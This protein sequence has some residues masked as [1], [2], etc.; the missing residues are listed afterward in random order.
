MT[1]L[2]IGMDI[3]ETKRIAES[4]ERFG[5][6]FLNRVFLEGEL[7]Y[8]RSMKFPHLHLA[9]RFAAKEAI[10]KAFGTGIGHEMGWRDLEIVREVTA[11]PRSGC[12][13]A[14]KATR[15]REGFARCTSASRTPPITAPQMRSSWGKRPGPPF[16]REG[17]CSRRIPG[18]ARCVP[19]TSRFMP[20]ST[21]TVFEIHSGIVLKG[22]LSML[23][24][25]I[26]AGK[27]EGELQTYGCLTVS[28]GGVVTGSIDA[29]ALVL[30]PGNL[31]EARV[32]VGEQVR[33][34]EVPPIKDK[35]AP[36]SWS[37][38]FQKLKEMALGR[39]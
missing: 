5:D 24:D 33:P 11:R 28:S 8:A 23:K 1:I 7:A 21:S 39:R 22:Q 18:Y 31:V 25:I 2:G 26:L 4:I 10:S 17:A 34:K 20:P 32:K 13:A 15:K 30:E 29:G 36:S 19:R 27:F 37:G 12:T 38:R 16:A 35:A 6:R 3:V 14:R 9:A